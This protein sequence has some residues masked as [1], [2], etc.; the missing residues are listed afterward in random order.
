MFVDY[1]G[2]MSTAAVRCLRATPTARSILAVSRRNPLSV[3]VATTLARRESGGS[4]QL[5]LRPVVAVAASPDLA[6]LV[7]RV[8]GHG[9]N[10]GFLV[11]QANVSPTSSFM[12]RVYVGGDGNLTAALP[13]MVAVNRNARR[14]KKVSTNSVQILWLVW[15]STLPRVHVVCLVHARAQVSTRVRRKDM[16]DRVARFPA[17]LVIA[18]TEPY[19]IADPNTTIL[20]RGAFVPAVLSCFFLN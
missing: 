18:E 14:P 7:R 5:S 4:L 19:A 6:S 11:S 2:R 8:D 15:C 17:R 13:E 1:Y 20:P 3:T 9:L 10:G 16:A 12:D